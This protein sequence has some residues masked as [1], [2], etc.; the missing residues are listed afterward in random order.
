MDKDTARLKTRGTTLH[1]KVHQL[2]ERFRTRVG[3]STSLQG[4]LQTELMD[5]QQFGE[6]ILNSLTAHIAVIDQQ[7]NI[8]IVNDAWQ[9]FAQESCRECADTVCIGSNYLT[10]WQHTITDS[11]QTTQAALA[12]IQ[13]VLSGAKNYF[14]LEYPC[15]SPTQERWFSMMVTPLN[16]NEG[17][18]VVAH[19]DISDKRRAELALRENEQRFQNLADNAPVLI[20]M[21]DPN[22]QGILYHNQWLEL[23]G[24]D[25][26][27]E[28]CAGWSEVIQPDDRERSLA[29]CKDAFNR[30]VSFTI[31]YRHQRH[32]GEYRWLLDTGT[33]CFATDGAFTGYIG[34]CIDITDRIQAERE[35][36]KL[37]DELAHVNRLSTMGELA[38]SLAHELNQPLTAILNNA[39][40]A[41]RFLAQDDP[42][43]EELRATVTDIADDDRRAG[44]VIQRLRALLNKDSLEQSPQDIGVVIH[45][46]ATL[47]HSDAMAKNII[48]TLQLDDDLPWVMGDEVQLQQVVLNL[49]VNGFDAMQQVDGA[50]EL[51]LKATRDSG[52]TITVSV[53][54]SGV[55]LHQ[56]AM[57]RM[58]DA[59]FTT[60]PGGMGMGL[61]ISRSIIE[62]HGGKL[63]AIPNGER[64]TTVHFR[65]PVTEAQ[66]L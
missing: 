15:S 59:F 39:Q 66:G 55:G 44:A 64:G 17:G 1:S 21:A 26:N 19:T 37:R 2:G 41:Q 58:F 16:N 47:L 57:M 33:P 46:V 34:S 14:E 62:A 11:N 35:A 43:L 45:E 51:V 61:S 60:K 54:D 40:S 13:S 28:L 63:W 7:G 50:N 25:K 31:E 30:R 5:S 32:D 9:R 23:T 38:A 65:L 48:L 42:D 22:H 20:W 4:A 3:A 52:E 8:I 24:R 29:I 53:A 49:V 6:S 36:R 12:G 27:Q 10:V 56:E 18:A